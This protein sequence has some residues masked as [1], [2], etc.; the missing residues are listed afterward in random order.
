[1]KRSESHWS[2]LLWVLALML[3]V[4]LQVLASPP[5]IPP[6]PIDAEVLEEM[7]IQG[8]A[9]YWVILDEQ[10]DLSGAALV[11]DWDARGQYVYDRLTSLADKSQPGLAST[12]ANSGAS[13]TR[14]WIVNAI[15]VTSGESVVRQ[16][17]AQSGVGRIV[18]PTTF[19][20]PEPIPATEQGQI[21][22][23]EWN[24]ARIRAP[25]VW[26][27]YGATGQGIVV[28]NI[29]T[30]VQFDHPAL[31]SKYRGNLGGGAFDHNYNWFDPSRVCGDPSLVPCD[32]N[33]H[34]TH[35]MG[36][37]VGGDAA[38]NQIGVAPGAR[39]IMAKG[40]EGSSC[41]DTALLASAQWILAPTDLS[42]ANPRPDLRPHVVNNSWGDVGGDSWYRGMVQAW[43]AAG[44]FPVF[45]SGNSGP[46]CGSAGSPGD[47]P[48]SYSVGAFDV[49]NVIGDFSG[50]G[51]SASLFGSIA[52]PNLAAPG[53]S[54]RSSY[55][56][57]I[58]EVLSGTS[59]AAPHVAGT[60]ALIWSAAPVLTGDVAATR[61]ILDQSAADTSDLQCG[62][63]VEKNNVWGEGRLDA[64]AAVSQ[65]P[66]GPAGVLQG[67]V[68]D[69]NDGLGI[70][71]A[72]VTV[73]EAGRAVKQVS[74]GDTGFY[75]VYLPLGTY[76]VEVSASGYQTGMAQITLDEV[77]ASSIQDLALGTP[78][79]EVSPASL[80]FLVPPGASRTQILVLANTGSLPMDWQ[81][82]EQSGGSLTAG[83]T[84]AAE[85]S[86]D[87][88]GHVHLDPTLHSRILANVLWLTTN[89][90]SGTVL[91]GGQQLIQVITN[92]ANAELGSQQASII[93]QT[94]SGRQP[95]L[96]VPVRLVVSDIH[97]Q[98]LPVIQAASSTGR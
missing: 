90:S 46:S 64:F 11:Q 79:G 91:A 84:A 14:Y 44:I 32:D 5:S 89:P 68:T 28:A 43:V 61:A 16:V 65:S 47:Y 66:F 20:V 31:V 45:S 29:D 77:G 10:A 88:V 34:G 92:A 87:E 42:G 72:V 53:V 39:F 19:Q 24:I 94:S 80:T 48:E 50:R 63:T 9:S 37:T 30:G 51:P 12:L 25:E 15:L 86:T 13:Y 55:P 1:M 78:R 54:V 36:T 95:N 73:L 62:G 59:M 33:G 40:C 74:T 98:F 70:S 81:I 82:A 21:D 76:D 58:Y 57:R 6:A 22:S 27:T 4:P 23:V 69:Y 71:G 75:R 8:T 41:S 60:V 35:T 93:V 97:R 96:T 52:K 2:R 56:E 83:A 17:A 18:A 67:T 3:L 7:A 26:S 38:N 85:R 49:D